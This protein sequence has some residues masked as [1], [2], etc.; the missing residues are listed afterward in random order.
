MDIE[1]K[2]NHAQTEIAS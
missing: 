2:T 1:E